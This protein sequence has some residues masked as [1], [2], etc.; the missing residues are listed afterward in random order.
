MIV[1]AKR[2]RIEFC[3]MTCVCLE[4]IEMGHCRKKEKEKIIVVYYRGVFFPLVFSFK[5]YS[6]SYADRILEDLKSF[7]VKTL[8]P[9]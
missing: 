8:F 7:E 5:S 6:V 3:A 2:D 9:S 1:R 4:Y